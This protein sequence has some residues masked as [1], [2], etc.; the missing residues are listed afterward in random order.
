[1]AEW[2]ARWA[3][4]SSS[5]HS[6]SL[7]PFELVFRCRSWGRYSG[8]WA[9]QPDFAALRLGRCCAGQASAAPWLLWQA[10]HSH[11]NAI[12][13][14]P[15][16]LLPLSTRGTL[17]LVAVAAGCLPLAAAAC[18]CSHGSSCTARAGQ[19]ERSQQMTSR[20]RPG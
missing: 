19:R 7:L 6:R 9:L 13:R 2:F 4:P 11:A 5:L 14:Q 15:P 10:A 1:M 18:S 12:S 17:P 8:A 20:R 16:P 3:H